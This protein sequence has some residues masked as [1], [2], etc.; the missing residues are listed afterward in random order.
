MEVLV[1]G[2]LIVMI[3]MALVLEFV[4]VVLEAV[5]VGVFRVVVVLVVTIGGR[6]L[7]CA[8]AVIGTFVEVLTVDM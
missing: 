1:G 3:S 8:G 5:R 7:V 2:I 6:A 4:I